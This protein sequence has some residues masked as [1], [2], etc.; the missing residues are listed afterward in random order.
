MGHAERKP[1]T[2]LDGQLSIKMRY[3]Q[4]RRI[5]G[6]VLAFLGIKLLTSH[7][8][9]G[10]CLYQIDIRCTIRFEKKPLLR[11][12]QLGSQLRVVEWQHDRFA[13]RFL[14]VFSQG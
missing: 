9:Y 6:Q 10:V 4:A 1:G 11:Q 12:D 2:I 8:R 3:Y 13:N 14:P 5:N 7:F